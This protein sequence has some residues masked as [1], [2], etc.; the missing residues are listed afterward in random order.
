[1]NRHLV[2]RLQGTMLMLVAAAS[3]AGAAQPSLRDRL[4]EEKKRSEKLLTE[5]TRLRN[6]LG[7]IEAERRLLAAELQRTTDTL[8]EHQLASESREP[9]PLPPTQRARF[10]LPTRAA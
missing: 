1:M 3:I 5:L 2:K 6:R 7:D 10:R 8:H 9:P 4:I